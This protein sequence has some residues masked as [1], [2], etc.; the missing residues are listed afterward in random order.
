MLNFY[1]IV[2]N[3][4]DTTLMGVEGLTEERDLLTLNTTW[5]F[6]QFS[7]VSVE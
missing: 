2:K 4:P 6:Y 3:W 5:F 7:L 1:T